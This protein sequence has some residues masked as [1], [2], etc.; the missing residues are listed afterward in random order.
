MMAFI[1]QYAFQILSIL[2]TFFILYFVLYTEEYRNY[3]N[4]KHTNP[5]EYNLVNNRRLYFLKNDHFV[6]HQSSKPSIQYV[7]ESLIKL[8]NNDIF[9]S[10]LEILNNP[11][12]LFRIAKLLSEN[13]TVNDDAICAIGSSGIALGVSTALITKRPLFF[14]NKLGFPEHN[15]SREIL[16]Y[17]IEPFIENK[18]RIVLIDS[19][20][21]TGFVCNKCY[22]TIKNEYNAIPTKILVPLS[23]N[24]MFNKEYQKTN[25]QIISLIDFDKDKDEICACYSDIDIKRIKNIV[26][27]DNENFWNY[28]PFEKKDYPY[29]IFDAPGILKRP[30]WFFI[31]SQKRIQYKKISKYVKDFK[32]YIEPTDEDIWNFFQDPNTIESLFTLHDTNFDISKYDYII[33]IGHLGTAIAITLSYYNRDHFKGSLVSY[34]GQHGLLPLP[35]NLSTKKILAVQMRL[36]TGVYAVDLY[37]RIIDLGGELSDLLTV[38]RPEKTRNI[39][40]LLYQNSLQWLNELGVNF[41]SIF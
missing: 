7:T 34:L 16:K 28:P 3:Q 19:H 41:Y 29:A 10:N 12:L 13:V 31:K 23:F 4:K 24:F 2:V 40:K 21:R 14:Y 37:K 38:F 30:G 20:I 5:F 6:I 1:S 26:S 9:F 22:E 36:N 8:I 17:H 18:K 27:K 15:T 25:F 35:N 33:G 11:T 39:K 32:D